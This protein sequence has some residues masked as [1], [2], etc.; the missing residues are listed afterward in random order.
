MDV[1]NWLGESIPIAR[2]EWGIMVAIIICQT[3]QRRK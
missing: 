2:W 3:C 1:I